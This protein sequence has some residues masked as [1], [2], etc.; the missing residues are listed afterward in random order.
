MASF[1]A[2][3]A[4]L[5]CAIAIE[6]SITAR[7]GELASD[8]QQQSALSVHIG[9]NAGEPVAEGS[10]LFG[11]TVQLARRICDEADAGEILV[12]DVVRQLAAGKDFLFADRGETVLRGF[13]DPVRLYELRWQDA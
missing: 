7:N 4:A 5:N 9:L 2:A 13:E 3:S 10:D 8:D 12:A 11:T 1:P 6:Q